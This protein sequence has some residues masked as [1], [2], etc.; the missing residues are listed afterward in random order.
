MKGLVVNRR[1]TPDRLAHT[2]TDEVGATAVEY[3][4][5]TALIAGVIVTVVATLGTRVTGLYNLLVGA[6]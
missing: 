6:F 5:L 4:L 3:A 2:L 1:R